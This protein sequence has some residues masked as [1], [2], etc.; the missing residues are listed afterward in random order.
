MWKK[1]SFCRFD[2]DQCTE[3]QGLDTEYVEV[4]NSRSPHTITSF[5]RKEWQAFI[6]GVKAGDFDLKTDTDADA[7]EQRDQE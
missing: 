3:V 2:P 1:S 7:E 4:R 6:D 5:D